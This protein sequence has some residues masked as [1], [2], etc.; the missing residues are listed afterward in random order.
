MVQANK[1]IK[2]QEVQPTASNGGFSLPIENQSDE[3]RQPE[4]RLKRVASKL[5]TLV[6]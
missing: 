5:P 3:N 6:L 4:N 2:Q 1:H